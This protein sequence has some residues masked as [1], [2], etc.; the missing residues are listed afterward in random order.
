[1]MIRHMV[2]DPVSIPL[3]PPSR[4]HVSM[5]ARGSSWGASLKLHRDEQGV[6][7]IRFLIDGRAASGALGLRLALTTAAGG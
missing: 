3:L 7:V 1:M 2:R 5:L 4:E 6:T